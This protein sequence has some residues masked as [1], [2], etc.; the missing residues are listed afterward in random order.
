MNEPVADAVRS[1]LDGHVVL[2]RKLAHAGHY[3]A[4]DVLQSVSRLV[5]EVVAPEV[6]SAGDEV[7][8]LLATYREKEDLIAI[9]AYQP[10]TDPRTDA[11][12]AARE[13]IEAFLKQNVVE[14]SSAAE[15]DAMVQQLAIVHGSAPVA[16]PSPLEAVAAPAVP[17]TPLHS[18]IPPLHLAA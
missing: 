6:R 14:P 13:P 18:A 7:R 16:L 11:A 5:G 1:I 15:A 2:S 10:G 8:R 12:I 4:I 9:G 3:P 17:E